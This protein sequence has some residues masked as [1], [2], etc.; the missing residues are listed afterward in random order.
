[1]FKLT[2]TNLTKLIKNPLEILKNIT[3]DDIASIL[4]QANHSY[5]NEKKPLFSD[6]IYDMIKEYLEEKNPNHPILK[7]VGAAVENNKEKLPYYMG[8]LD[9]IKE[10]VEKFK[11]KYPDSYIISDKLDGNSGLFV[12]KDKIAKLYSRGD[13]T[14]GQNISHLLPFLKGIPSGLSKDIAV[15][16]EII[17]S[18]EAFKKVAN[19]GANARNMVAGLLNA[20]LPDLE[21]AQLTEFISYEIISP[22]LDPK[23]Q[24]DLLKELKFKPVYHEILDEKSLTEDNLTDILIKR[25]DKS[26]HEIDGIVVMHNKIHKRNTD[27]N[28]NY[29]FAFKSIHTMTKAEVIVQN[30]EWNLSKDGYLIPTV[31]F[32]SVNIDGVTI[33]RATGFNGKFIKDNKIGPGS[34]IIIIRG[35]LVIPHIEKVLTS[36]ETGEPQMPDIDYIWTDS[37]VHI[38]IKVKNSEFEFKNFEFFIKKM[39]ITSLGPGNIKKIFDAGIN[40]PKKLFN[41]TIQD[42]AKIN[43]FKDKMASKIYDA[44]QECKSKMTCLQIMTASN[45]MGRGLGVKKLELIIEAFPDILKTRYVPTLSELVKLKGVETTTANLFIKNLP[46]FF[47]FIDNNELNCLNKQEK[48]PMIP[49]SSSDNI[50]NGEKIVFTGFRNKELE[51]IIKSKGGEVIG[52]ISKKTTIVITKDLKHETAK[53]TKA[54]ELGAKII[55]YADFLKLYKINL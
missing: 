20:K 19:K 3:D 32:G 42:F 50:L 51:D 18:K 21:I 39:E 40:N 44:I 10:N 25:R 26:P 52:T 9:K 7:N 27:G 23:E 29:G 37:G 1:M 48:S 28:P 31:I 38:M 35:G 4:Q 2:K 8:S 11:K 53:V 22:K 30:V 36:S 45:V 55:D 54:K 34:K 46:N 43:S 41:A 5:Y 6:N 33:Q 16:G 14:I 13:G 17:L 24:M 49:A 15:R 12:F 47:E